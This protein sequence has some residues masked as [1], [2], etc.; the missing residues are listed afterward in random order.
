MAE[1]GHAR[2]VERF[3]QLISFVQGYGADYAPAN[4]A[5]SL[6][7]LQ[8]KLTESRAGIDGV[9]ST[10]APWIVV[11]N[12]RQNLFAELRPRMTRVVN[13][14]AASGPPSNA[15]KDVK[16]LKRKIDGVKLKT[17]PKASAGA[18]DDDGKGSSASQQSFTQLTEH[19]DNL[20]ELLTSSDYAPNEPDLK[21]AALAAYSTSLKTV[22]TAV[23]N[24]TTPWSNARITRDET[25]YAE[26][27][28][29]V[30][31]AGLVKKYVKSL[32]GADSPQYKQISGLGFSR[33]NR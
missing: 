31:L 21:L 9:S 20:I 5:I 12:D 18:P 26:G 1:T 7:N 24:A 32:F 23:I 4:T 33:P 22:N 19:L 15:I 11:V 30:A 10:K 2:N 27:A 3:A 8:A 13:G 29:L 14:F 17:A 6:A 16:T 28:G 25:L